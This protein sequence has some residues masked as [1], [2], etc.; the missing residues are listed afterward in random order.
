MSVRPNKFF[1]PTSIDDVTCT[2]EL[3]S[4][5]AIYI[6]LPVSFNLFKARSRNSVM[7]RSGGVYLNFSAALP[8]R[9]KLCHNAG[10]LLWFKSRL[11]SLWATDSA[12]CCRIT[13]AL[14][15]GCR[16]RV[17]FCRLRWCRLEEELMGCWEN[18]N[19][20]C[21]PLCYS[22]NTV[23]SVICKLNLLNANRRLFVVV[24]VLH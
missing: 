20:C 4:K 15:T 1:S 11:L 23:H 2:N 18:R 3:H 21:L 6:H 5:P 7:E 17:H 14:C 9:A 22:V 24:V 16:N 8:C 12:L 10:L 19:V 13:K